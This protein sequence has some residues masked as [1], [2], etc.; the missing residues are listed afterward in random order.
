LLEQK[1]PHFWQKESVTLVRGKGEK[2]LNS[3]QGMRGGKKRSVLEL[4]KIFERKREV[5]PE[6]EK[7]GPRLCGS[8]EERKKRG[9][10][11]LLT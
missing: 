8:Y 9:R 10:G 3:T 2:V 11:Q 6:K 7:G 1:G 5:L 4:G